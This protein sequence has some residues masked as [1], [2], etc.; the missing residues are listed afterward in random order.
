MPSMEERIAAKM[1]KHLGIKEPK[2]IKKKKGERRLNV[3]K[4]LD[5][6]GY[7]SDQKHLSDRN[8]TLHRLVEC[9]FDPGHINE[10]AIGQYDNGTLIYQCFHDSCRKKTWADARLIISGDESLSPWME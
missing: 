1:K 9:L 6:H 8:L 2:P 3:P 10:S 5:D 7:E 4:Y